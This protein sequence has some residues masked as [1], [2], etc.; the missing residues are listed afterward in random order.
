[1]ARLRVLLWLWMPILLTAA[2]PRAGS[3]ALEAARALAMED[4]NGGRLVLV[5]VTVPGLTVAMTDE[6]AA[7]A[8]KQWGLDRSEILFAATN[9][10]AA[11]AEPR[12]LVDDLETVIAAALGRLSK[13][14]PT[15]FAVPEPDG[16]LWQ[17][18]AAAL[19]RGPIRASF[20]M[21]QLRN[22]LEDAPH[23]YGVHVVRFGKQLTVL[24]LSGPV[25][26]SLAERARREFPSRG[27]LILPCCAGSLKALGPA[28]EEAVIEAIGRLSKRTSAN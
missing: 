23:P 20:S 7:R 12:Q 5:Y 21:L 24:A 18:D 26:R 6:V 22:S 16:R 15:R 8:Q 27:L 19:S 9:D 11:A 17:L 14:A 25:S 1:M 10:A 28:S 13:A 2:E 4:G 3:A